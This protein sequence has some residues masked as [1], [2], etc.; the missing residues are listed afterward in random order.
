MKQKAKLLLITFLFLPLCVLAQR[1]VTVKGKV[2]EAE[3]NEPLPGV[4]ILV[5]K[6]TRGVTT[7][8]DGTFEI[9]VSTS[10]KLVF[11]F[12]GMQSQTIE[13]GDKTYLEVS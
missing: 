13:V 1:Q 3:T 10:D 9:R 8:M 4:T 2:I 6:S 11:S 5:E 12:V 7:D